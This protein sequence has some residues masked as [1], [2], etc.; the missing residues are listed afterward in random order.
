[1][2]QT[3]RMPHLPQPVISTA[4]RSKNEPTKIH[5]RAYW[6]DGQSRH[7]LTGQGEGLYRLLDAQLLAL[8]YTGPGSAEDDPE[9]TPVDDENGG[10]E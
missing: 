2:R 6:P 4:W 8:G 1:M 7:L 9:A 5:Y 10:R 3:E